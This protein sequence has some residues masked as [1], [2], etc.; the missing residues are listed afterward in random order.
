MAY[1]PPKMIT[2]NAAPILSADLAYEAHG[3]CGCQ[4]IILSS[5]GLGDTI[6]EASQPNKQPIING[7]TDYSNAY[8]IVALEN[9]K[10][11][12][13]K[14]NNISSTQLDNAL[15]FANSAFI[16]KPES[17]ILADFT[18]VEILTG[19]LIIYRDCSQS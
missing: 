12:R 7:C 8:K 15:V 4:T 11:R 10:F 18:Y 16:L 9:T 14:A 17:E 5:D 2:N 3:K 6:W 1:H 19:T 13:I